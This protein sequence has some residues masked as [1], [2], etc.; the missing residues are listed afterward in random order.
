METTGRALVDHW[1]WAASKGL[2]NS[3]TAKTFRAACVQ[4]L[5]VLE[6]WER[7]DVRALD[8]EEV[9]A[10]FLNVRGRDFAPRSL[11][12]YRGRFKQAVRSYLAYVQDPPSWKPHLQRENSSGQ[13][14]SAA[15]AAGRRSRRP[16]STRKSDAAEMENAARRVSESLP[17]DG[18]YYRWQL[19]NGATAELKLSAR[20]TSGDLGLLL[21]YVELLKRAVE[22]S[23]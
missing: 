16:P 1:D 3:N 5:G 2:M 18:A 10:R 12:D 6:D 19:L 23:Y 4:V 20:P 11:K 22:T 21:E 13:R 15:G 14:N 8:P 17:P 7:T 9:F